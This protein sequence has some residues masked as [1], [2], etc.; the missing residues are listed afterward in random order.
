MNDSERPGAIRRYVVGPVQALAMFIRALISPVW[1]TLPIVVAAISFFVP[2]LRDP[3]KNGVADQRLWLFMMV[4][5]VIL[6]VIWNI[7]NFV[8]VNAKETKTH[9][10][11]YDHSVTTLVTG[12]LLVLFGALLVGFEIFGMRFDLYWGYFVPLFSAIVDQFLTGHFGLN[13][14]AQ[15]PFMDRDDSKS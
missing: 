14:A 2:L 4:Q 12:T 7:A 1:W 9:E 10:L 11:Q 15:K 13:N 8:V 6:I 5:V 3:V